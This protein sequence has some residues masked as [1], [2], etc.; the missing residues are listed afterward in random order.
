MKMDKAEV[1]KKIH[2]TKIVPV[3]RADSNDEARKLIDAILA[4]GIN[5]IEI[6]MSVPGAV[7]LI[8]TLSAEFQNTTVIGAGTVL[9]EKTTRNCISAGAKFI[10]SPMFSAEIIKICRESNVAA[11]PGALT[12]TEIFAAWKSGAD[13]VKV[14]PISATGGVSYIKAVKSV[15]SEIKLMPTGGVNL[16]NIAEFIKAGVFA[17]GIGS[18]LADVKALRKFGAEIMV[19]LGI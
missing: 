9:D 6:T 5:I 17:V 10:I 13:V 1:L 15:L 8:D 2:E 12:P 14:F 16:Q 11:M 7:Q 4:G 3:I 19:L 18:D